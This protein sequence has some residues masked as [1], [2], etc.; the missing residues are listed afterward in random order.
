MAHI[1]VHL[2]IAKLHA[3]PFRVGGASSRYFSPMSLCSAHSQKQRMVDVRNEEIYGPSSQVL[4]PSSISLVQSVIRRVTRENLRV[5]VSN[6][7]QWNTIRLRD[8]C[9]LKRKSN[10]RKGNIPSS[11]VTSTLRS[12]IVMGKNSIWNYIKVIQILLH[13]TPKLIG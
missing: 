9:T 8:Y 6:C 5:K 3:S 10:M 2:Q 1:L 11:Q 13:N 4:T 7:T 12:A